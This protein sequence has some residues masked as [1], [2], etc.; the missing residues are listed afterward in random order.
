MDGGVLDNYPQGSNPR[1]GCLILIV[2]AIILW[3]II[4]HLF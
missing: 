3:Y 1:G 2:G 4:I